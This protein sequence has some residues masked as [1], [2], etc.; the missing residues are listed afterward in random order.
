M[1]RHA[2]FSAPNMRET[3]V[4]EWNDA[5]P[6]GVFLGCNSGM[7]GTT[8]DD[9]TARK[10][11]GFGQ[12]WGWGGYVAGNLYQLISTQQKHLVH[13]VF[14]GV[15][16]NPE[17]PDEWLRKISRPFFA[18]EAWGN[19]PEKIKAAWDSRVLEIRRAVLAAGGRPIRAGSN[20]DGSPSHL[21]RLP[22][23]DRPSCSF[24]QSWDADHQHGL[25]ACW[26]FAKQNGTKWWGVDGRNASD[27]EWK[28]AKP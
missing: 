6:I 4:R 26:G 3:L 12:R 23:V 19:A 9:A 15:R 10:Y 24:C 21:S 11:V 16:V 27:C 5:L 14:A 22:Y 18:C 13:D 20:K 28:G 1:K 2:T 7:A 8:Y 17:E 25:A